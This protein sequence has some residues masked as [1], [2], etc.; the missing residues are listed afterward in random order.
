MRRGAFAYRSDQT[1]KELASLADAA[2]H[3]AD[4]AGTAI[5]DATGFH[6]RGNRRIAAWTGKA[7][8]TPARKPPNERHGQDLGRTDFHDQTGREVNR[9]ADAMKS[10]QQKTKGLTGRVI[11]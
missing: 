5:D 4:Q 7:A 3:A 9:Q 1:D 8:R 10:R 6:R 2:K 11:G